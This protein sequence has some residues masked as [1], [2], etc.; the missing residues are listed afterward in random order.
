VFDLLFLFLSCSMYNA[1]LQRGG[2]RHLADDPLYWAQG[3]AAKWTGRSSHS[4]AI[5]QDGAILVMGGY[6]NGG[7]SNEVWK[8]VDEGSSWSLVTSKAWSGGG[9]P[10][11]EL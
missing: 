11:T 2:G 7:H 3:P 10:D 6:G 9:F 5:L 4:T 1:S 8:S